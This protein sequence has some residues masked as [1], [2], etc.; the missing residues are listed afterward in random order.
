MLKTPQHNSENYTTDA[1]V[2]DGRDD[3]ATE[4]EAPDA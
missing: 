2:D 1:N 3:N 4:V